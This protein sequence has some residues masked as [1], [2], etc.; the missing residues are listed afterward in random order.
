MRITSI[1]VKDKPPIKNFEVTD[2]SNT[3]VIAGPNGIGKTRLIQ[4]IISILRNPKPDQ[5][6]S[7]KISAT[8]PDERESWG[9]DILSTLENN[10]SALLRNHIQKSRKRG[11]WISSIVNF[12]SSRTFEPIQSFQWSWNF[13][14]PFDEDIGWD[15]L[16][17]PF[18]SRYQDTIHALYRKMGHYRTEISKK[19][20]ELRKAGQAQ[21][22]IDPTEPLKKFRDAFNILLSPKELVDIPVENPKIQYLENGQLLPIDNLSSGERE[23]FTIVFDLLLHEP[24]DCIIFF[25][26]PEVHLHP[27]LSFR[28][29]RSLDN[30]G[31]GNQFIFCTHSADI[32]TQSL[33]HSVIFLKPSD[34][35]RNQA[36]CVWNEEEKSTAL[37]LLG[38][39]LGVIA[40][41]R[42]IVLIEGNETS[43]DKLTYGEIVGHMYPQYVLV[44]IGSRQTA[45]S[46]SQI[47]DDV[48]SKALWG[49]DFFM[50]ADHDSN[51]PE[52]LMAEL[53][54]KSS[55]RLAFLPRYHLENYFLDENVI[56][57][58]FKKMEAPDSWLCNNTLINDKL[59]QIALD[60]IPYAVQLHLSSSI[61]S[62]VGEIEFTVKDIDKMSLEEYLTQ[63]EEAISKEQ[64]RINSIIDLEQIKNVAKK[65]WD[66]LA[67][68]I[69]NDN[70]EWK[71]VIPG[72]VVCHKFA[73]LTGIDKGRFK[74]MYI[75]Q[76]REEG[77]QPFKE[78]ITIFESFKA[79]LL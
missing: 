11:K 74:K 28:L 63:L 18:R 39:N 57:R 70:S 54:S 38:Q 61:R 22:Q 23:V 29:L 3:V 41:G 12:D 60:T 5:S 76:S 79:F 48:L 77:Y 50:I 65:R 20:E 15:V 45:L 62:R 40:F 78:I 75:N 27:E 67:M 66:F 47:I 33:N 25:D 21:M 49:I 4:Q 6:L 1:I 55:K 56:S 24:S 7:V 37:N 68:L 53:V 19:Y 34:G 17:N 69:T 35:D 58:M 52:E 71:K 13:N 8:S 9:K 31:E 32:I 16:F 59:K 44:P 2:L 14:D 73:S 72:R 36:L 10:D 26:E 42:K 43:L 64:K 46:F 30:V 51:L